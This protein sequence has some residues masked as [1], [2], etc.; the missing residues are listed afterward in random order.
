MATKWA[1]Y[2]ISAVQ[3]NAAGTH[4]DKVRRHPDDGDAVG[5][6]TDV[7]RSS[8]VS[9]LEAG[10]TFATITRDSTNSKWVRGADVEVITVDGEKYIRTD[11]DKTK[12]DNLGQLPRF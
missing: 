11:R 3:Y 6:S 9:Q 1:D 2:L 10:T 8:V 5:S 4:I 12:K 7:L